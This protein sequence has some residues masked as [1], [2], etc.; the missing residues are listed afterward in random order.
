MNLATSRVSGLRSRSA[1]WRCSKSEK[2]GEKGGEAIRSLA[3][4]YSRERLRCDSEDSDLQL[5]CDP[6]DEANFSSSS[7]S[8]PPFFLCWSRGSF[9]LF[10]LLLSVAENIHF[11]GKRRRRSEFT[12]AVSLLLFSH[13][14]FLTN[15]DPRAKFAQSL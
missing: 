3:P 12:R 6:N 2:A 14:D 9:F 7:A 13:C 15:F 10:I 5:A 4:R 1:G 11:L 8:T